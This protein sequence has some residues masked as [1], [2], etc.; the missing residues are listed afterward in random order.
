MINSP[1]TDTAAFLQEG[2]IGNV[3]GPGEW[4]IYIGDEP[5]TP[6]NCIT[7]YDYQGGGL[8]SPDERMYEHFLQVRVRAIAYATGYDK[9]AAVRDWLAV[10]TKSK[11]VGDWH[12]IGFWVTADI[13]SIGRDQQNRHL[14]VCNF[15]L[16]REPQP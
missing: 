3:A 2:A 15:R 14:L 16:H 12:Y 4:P 13:A 1:A 10:T 6:P 11:V 8:L 9:M 5:A 7:V